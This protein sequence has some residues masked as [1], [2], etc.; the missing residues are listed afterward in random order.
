MDLFTSKLSQVVELSS[1]VIVCASVC[2]INVC[3]LPKYVPTPL[4]LDMYPTVGRQIPEF[5]IRPLLHITV[6]LVL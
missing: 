5:P 6:S 2:S 4:V 3:T 1:P